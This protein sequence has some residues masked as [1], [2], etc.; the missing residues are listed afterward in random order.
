M[1]LHYAGNSELFIVWEPLNRLW[2]ESIFCNEILH[3]KIFV[4][5]LLTSWGQ[6]DLQCGILQEVASRKYGTNFGKI[7]FSVQMIT[8]AQNLKS[9]S[10]KLD[11]R[12]KKSCLKKIKSHFFIVAVTAIISFFVHEN[13]SKSSKNK[14]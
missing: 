4:Y 8:V 7:P 12:T 9:S 13:K 2:F 5:L 14:N 10:K 1:T 11:S 3:V 6:E